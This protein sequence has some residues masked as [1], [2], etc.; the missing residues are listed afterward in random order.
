MWD[1]G[2]EARC[3]VCGCPVADHIPLRYVVKAWIW[4]RVAVL[5]G[6]ST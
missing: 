5:L 6:R 4:H 3:I 2:P 1:P